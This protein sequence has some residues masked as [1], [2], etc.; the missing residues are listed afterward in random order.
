MKGE[1]LIEGVNGVVR[2]GRSTDMY[3][4]HLKNLEKRCAHSLI[5]GLWGMYLCNMR[6][7]VKKERLPV[8]KV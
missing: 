3:Q 4:R 2:K 5:T 7:E 6:T 8:F 1:L